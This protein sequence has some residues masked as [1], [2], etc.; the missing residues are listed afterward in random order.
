MSLKDRIRRKKEELNQINQKRDSYETE[1]YLERYE[2]LK[3]EL[4][5]YLNENVDYN[6]YAEKY[7]EAER[8]NLLKEC[9]QERLDNYYPNM[10]ISNVEKQKLILDVISENN[11]LGPLSQL[12]DDNSVDVIYVN[13]VNEVLVE[14]ESK[15]YRT[16]I[17][18]RNTKHLEQTIEKI[19]FSN[20][21]DSINTDQKSFSKKMQNGTTINAILP[22]IA[23]NGGYI[24]I[25]KFNKKLC[26]FE[27]LIRKRFLTY[28]MANFLEYAYSKG[29]NIVITGNSHSGK[30]TLLSAMAKADQTIDRTVLIRQSGEMEDFPPHYLVLNEKNENDYSI[31]EMA[32]VLNP[33]KIVYPDINKDDLIDLLTH[34]EA[35]IACCATAKNAKELVYFLTKNLASEN[36]YFDKNYIQEILSNS[37]DLIVTTGRDQDNTLRVLSISQINNRDKE[38]P[39]VP[40]IEYVEEKDENGKTQSLYKSSGIYPS[41]ANAEELEDFEINFNFFENDYVH[42]YNTGVMKAADVIIEEPLTKTD[43]A[44]KHNK[45]SSIK[46]RFEE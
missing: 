4:S 45:K 43:A 13:G 9:I 7:T 26:N 12:Y 3:T 15:T 22:P 27:E 35:K 28:E 18:F 23:T 30:T 8:R 32:N 20:K 36:A 19:F 40:L 10:F 41:F 42:E 21:V 46:T 34:S 31:F 39:I 14:K 44:F 38:D 1:S 33:V 2:N 16:S 37:I 11:F 5:N 24:V 17:N 29:L 6:L 25:K